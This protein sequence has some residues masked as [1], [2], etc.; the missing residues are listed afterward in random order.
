[1]RARSGIP[2]FGPCDQDRSWEI[3]PGGG[4]R[5]RVAPL[6][7]AAVKSPELGRV[8]ATTVFGVAGIGQRG[9]E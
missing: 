4:E 9:G 5:L 3:R 1:M 8:R 6:L 7:F 2:R